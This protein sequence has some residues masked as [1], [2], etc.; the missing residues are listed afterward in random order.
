MSPCNIT[1]RLKLW[2]EEAPYVKERAKS[3]H[4]MVKLPQCP[5]I[6]SGTHVTEG[7]SARAGKTA[8]TLPFHTQAYVTIPEEMLFQ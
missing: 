3:L 7:V 8:Q 6:P 2:Q 5:W 1:R 4:I